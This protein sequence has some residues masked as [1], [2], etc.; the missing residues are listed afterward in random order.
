MDIK[1]IDALLNKIN[2]SATHEGNAR[3][4]QVVNR[5]IRDLFITIDELDVTPNE[6]WSALNYLGEAGQ[7]GEL[8]L[9]AAGLGFEH[10]LDVRL[11]EAEARAGLQG[12]TP[13][14]IEGPLYVAGAPEST[15][16]AR[17][18]NGNEPGE[19]LVMRGRVLDEAGQPVRDALVEV[20]H[21]NHLG[22]YSHFDKSQ[23]AFNL[24]RSIRT[25]ENGTYSFRSV[26]PIGYSVPPEGKTQQLLDLLGRHG[27]RPAHIHFFVSAPGFRKLTTQINIEGDPYLWDDFA[28]ATRE[29][30]VP[31]V[32]K[33]EGAT[34]KPYGID[35]QFALIDFDFSLVKD[36]NNVPT[37]EVERVRA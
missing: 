31:A 24:R 13:R 9:L 37:S 30:L 15:G 1:T 36:R 26:V 34:G 8:G 6:F 18:D 12:G 33:E 3:T 17:L 11:D 19:T 10:F 14:T 7:S 27:H 21:A 20:W 23:P 25:D 28:F 22:N 5:I 16:H 29:G 4:K 35:G 2:E 32:K